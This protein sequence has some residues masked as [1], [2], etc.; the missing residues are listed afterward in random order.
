MVV[1]SNSQPIRG[2]APKI[3]SYMVEAEECG[4]EL[5]LL[6]RVLKRKDTTPAKKRKSNGN[7]YATT[8]GHSSSDGGHMALK[9]F[10]LSQKRLEVQV[11][12]SA[13]LT[14]PV[15]IGF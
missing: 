4:Y 12:I 11:L 2:Q 10:K 1:G 7:G 14:E 8:S 5:N 15:P 3:P 13:I 6:E 9:V